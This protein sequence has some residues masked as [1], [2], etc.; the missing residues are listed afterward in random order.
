MSPFNKNVSPLLLLALFIIVNTFYMNAEAA[1]VVVYN[2]ASQDSK[3]S[4]LCSTIVENYPAQL[5][6]YTVDQYKLIADTLVVTC[7][8]QWGEN[9]H[10]F[11]IFDPQRDTCNSCVWAVRAGGPCL[12]LNSD[13]GVNEQCYPWAF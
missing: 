7:N 11:D 12:Q 4:V 9:S 13:I 2:Y 5:I 8:F 6:G 3:L 1:E 10:T